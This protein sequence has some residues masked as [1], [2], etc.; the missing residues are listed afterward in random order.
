LKFVRWVHQARYLPQCSGLHTT[1]HAARLA[2]I[3]PEEQYAALELFRGDMLR[4]HLIAC[5]ADQ[6]ESQ[7]LNFGEGNW[8]GTV[9]LRLPEILVSKNRLPGK[10]A[11]LIN[12]ANVDLELALP[13]D[14]LELQVF[15]AID[16]RRTVAEIIQLAAAQ[17]GKKPDAIQGKA[18]LLFEQ[19]WW[20]DLVGGFISPTKCGATEGANP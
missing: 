4:H 12:P 14:E 9:P 8:L 17:L 7:A 15:N 16:S 19:L 6:A 11:V 5:H 13:M 2:K 1:P 10:V 18:R 20:Y 3:A